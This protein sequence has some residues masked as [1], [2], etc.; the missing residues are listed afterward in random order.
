VSV[1]SDAAGAFKIYLPKSIVGKN[2]RVVAQVPN[3]QDTRLAYNL[4]T[5]FGGTDTGVISEDTAVVSGMLREA[6]VSRLERLF[7]QNQS[8]EGGFESLLPAG[9]G[10]LAGPMLKDLNDAIT[11]GKVAELDPVRR[12]ALARKTA[13]QLLAFVDLS[14]VE[15]PT[16]GAK[17][18]P[19]LVAVLREVREAATNK[20]RADADYF[21]KQEVLISANAGLSADQAFTIKKPADLNDFLLRHVMAQVDREKVV[22]GINAVLGAVSVPLDRK[23]TVNAAMD[24]LLK[25]IGITMI[26]TPEAKAAI[27]VTIKAGQ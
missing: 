22:A 24:S 20:M 1:Y 17:V 13:D 19:A 2:V 5:S 3:S 18:V 21:T 10:A 14:T 27:I 15:M 26:T 16:G 8:A 4:V 25:A 12:R 11:A 9:A 7:E 23:D 6:F